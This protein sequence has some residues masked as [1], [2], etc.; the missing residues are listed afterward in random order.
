MGASIVCILLMRL[1]GNIP[2]EVMIADVFMVRIS[3][4]IHLLQEMLSFAMGAN[5][6]LLK[7]EVSFQGEIWGKWL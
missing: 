4:V 6:G 3:L 1:I 5:P 7:T 2:V